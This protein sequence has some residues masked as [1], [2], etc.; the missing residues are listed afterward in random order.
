VIASES[1]MPYYE[2]LALL[3]LGTA[4]HACGQREAA[5][6]HLAEGQRIAE[7]AAN[8]Y[9]M[10]GIALKQAQIAL[11]SGDEA[12]GLEALGNAFAI[13]RAEGYVNTEYWEP[14]VMAWLCARAIAAG[15]EVEFARELIRVRELL[16]DDPATA[17][18]G[19]PW[20]L[21]VYCLGESRLE[22]DGVPVKFGRKVPK[23]PLSIVRVLVAHREKAVPETKVI[24][25]LWPHEEADRA[26]QSL[27]IAIHRLRD[28]L[29][30][31]CVERREGRL[32][33]DRRRVWTDVWVFERLVE[34]A[35]GAT[36][37]RREEE[38]AACLERALAIYRGPFLAE[39]LDQ[40]WAIPMRERM[41][42]LFSRAVTDLGMLKENR[43]EWEAAVRLYTKGL[44]M[45]LL[46]EH[47]YQRLMH[48]Y[49]RA[50]RRA[51]ALEVYRRCYRALA[52]GLGI[53][54]SKATQRLYRE[55]AD[56]ATRPTSEAQ[57][58]QEATPIQSVPNR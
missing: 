42:S 20:K 17:G 19:W 43:G 12:G 1:G 36:G 48:C 29:G 57:R 5:L 7:A 13:G 50:E 46:A 16:P 26:H 52:R 24:E 23:K 8:R 38:R 3:M 4:K 55:I 47:F 51:E 56:G 45:D 39:D 54:P 40:A 37:A 44:E 31:P 14:R 2:S 53:E 34:E 41:R 30:G 32:S 9:I 18:E 58:I 49:A 33:L 11:E 22:L 35:D 27:A 25:A 21:K 15:I 10:F 28:L 6:C